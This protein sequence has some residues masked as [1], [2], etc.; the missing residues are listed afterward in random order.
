MADNTPATV[1]KTEIKNAIQD[2]VES[3]QT[4]RYG[5]DVR[6]SI[7]NAFNAIADEVDTEISEISTNINASI[8]RADAA[9]QSIEENFETKFDAFKA[10]YDRTIAALDTSIQKTKT[11]AEFIN[12]IA[13]MLSGTKTIGDDP[14]QT[15]QQLI[16]DLMGR[17]GTILE[18][19]SENGSIVRNIYSRMNYTC[20]QKYDV[21]PE[22]ITNENAITIKNNAFKGYDAILMVMAFA[23][24]HE[25][26]C[27]AKDE[28]GKEKVGDL[29]LKEESLSWKNKSSDKKATAHKAQLVTQISGTPAR[30]D[31]SAW[32]HKYTGQVLIINGQWN[33][34]VVY[35]KNGWYA[36][37]T[38]T[39]DK[40]TGEIKSDAPTV[41]GSDKDDVPI[42]D[43]YEDSTTWAESPYNGG[44]TYNV[45]ANNVVSRENYKTGQVLTITNYRLS[46]KAKRRHFAVPYLIYGV[47]GISNGVVSMEEEPVEFKYAIYDSSTLLVTS[48]VTLEPIDTVFYVKTNNWQEIEGHESEWFV[49]DNELH[50]KNS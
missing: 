19:I 29:S 4:A 12:S 37:R 8:T 26:F 3:I 38:W 24:K 27:M 49:F 21:L 2:Y 50:H 13:D 15:G 22:A 5:I 11:S 48:V 7:T 42:D 46:N 39:Y 6:D 14:E 44:K 35:A 34:G 28:N 20:L 1:Y 32:P 17:M 16:T 31:M 36:A 33:T 9:S 30:Y 18:A 45:W 40:E 47:T 10:A 25:F 41:M 43:L 23:D